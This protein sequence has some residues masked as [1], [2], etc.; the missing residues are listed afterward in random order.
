MFDVMSITM[1]SILIKFIIIIIAAYIFIDIILLL[2]LL[3]MDCRLKEG[4]RLLTMWLIMK[5]I[6]K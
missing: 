2:P 6:Y 1:G 5:L 3:W 4:G